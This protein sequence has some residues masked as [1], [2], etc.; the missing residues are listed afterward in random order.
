MG[1]GYVTPLFKRSQ[2]PLHGHRK[3]FFGG[4]KQLHNEIN[5]M[6]EGAI[7]Q[8]AQVQRRRTTVNACG[9]LSGASDC[10]CL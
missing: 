2:P 8:H 10:L 9:E 6:L 7:P 5:R 4:S 1:Y 3:P